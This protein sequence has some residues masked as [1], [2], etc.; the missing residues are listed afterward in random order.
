[1]RTAIQARFNRLLEAKRSETDHDNTVVLDRKSALRLLKRTERVPFFAHSYPFIHNM[2]RGGFTPR[3]LAGFAY[4]HGLRGL[5]LH[6]ND[7]GPSS[8]SAMSADDL[9]EFREH[10]AGLGLALHLEISSTTSSEVDQVTRLAVA[11]GVENI[12]F[13]ARHE[14]RLSEVMEKIYRDLCYACDQAARLNLHFDYEQHEDLKAAEI[15]SLIERAGDRRLRVLFDYSNSINAFEHPLAA[16]RALAPY[17]RQVHVK[18][19]RWTE[20]ESGWGQVGVLQGS[21]DD[22]LPGTRLLYE[23]LMLGDQEPQVICFALEQEVDYYAPPFRRR[24]E[25]PDPVI[26]YREPSD[27]PPDPS[28]AL[29]R[30]LIDE[31]RWAVDQVAWNRAV[32]VSLRELAAL[33]VPDIGADPF[34]LQGDHHQSQH[35][36]GRRPGSSV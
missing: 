7:G 32:V 14:G 27:T 3:D 13:Y 25:G 10:L 29:D 2:S 24:A 16:L 6:I 12:R 28:K 33:V 21:E 20:E 15:A 8:L 36:G 26:S 5:C 31:R 11:L 22:E 23:L 18:G 9:A 34:G 4:C 19:A 17:I 1:M 35:G 30:L